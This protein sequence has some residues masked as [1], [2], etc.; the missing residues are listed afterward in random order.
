MNESK[1]QVAIISAGMISNAAHIPAY[2]NLSDR[3]EIVG[4]CDL[5]PV[6]AEGTARRHGIAHWYTDAETMLKEQKPDLVSVCTPNI[7]HKPMT[8]L[9]LNYGCHVAC[10]KP[11]ALTYADTKALFDLAKA[12]NRVLIA[13]QTLRYNDE[14]S[15]AREMYKTG[16][17]GDIY[18]AEFSVLRRRGIPKWGTFHRMDANG[19]GCLC[20]LGV[21]LIDAMLWVMD[22]P[23]LMAVTGASAAVFGNSE[24]D[25]VTSLKESGAPAGVHNA[26]PY[27]PEEFEV[28]EFAAGAMRL[29]NGCYVN[30]KTSW[31]VNLPDE[32]F[33]R[34]AGTKAGLALPT[35]QM[36]GNM[37]RYQA[38]IQPRVFGE[39]KY[40]GKDFSGHFYLMED[41][42]NHLQNGAPLPILP[43]ETMNVT[44]VIE[45]YYI[46]AREHREVSAEE[47]R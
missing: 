1:L 29:S 27:K 24:T 34:F 45:A 33:M 36:Y 18:Y 10:E 43:E 21:H 38:N 2:K 6:S 13:C 19:G 11:L 39:G 40:A 17:L 14:Y 5:N 28:E 4:I 25:I 15:F 31:A 9:A 22:S 46:S 20:D 35:M 42:V 41:L 23:K 44:K 16:Q 30:F 3:V 7:A 26:R 32:Y 47:I 12:K 37:G 8:E